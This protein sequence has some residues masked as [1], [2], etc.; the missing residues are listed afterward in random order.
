MRSLTSRSLVC[1]TL[2]FLVVSSG[3]IAA[4]ECD[5]IET[6]KAVLQFV[7]DDGNNPL[8]SYAARN[9]TTGKASAD[10]TSQDSKSEKPL[11]QLGQRMVTTSK[12]KDKLTVKCSGGISAAVGDI[13]A[14]KEVT[15]TV[16][17][18]SDGTTSVSVDPF[19]F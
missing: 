17:Q 1:W 6:R 4:P 5:S 15:F 16:Q 9:S 19:Q 10:A 7:L 3:C 8:V 14:T 13:K 2:L 12:S 11:Y 18:S